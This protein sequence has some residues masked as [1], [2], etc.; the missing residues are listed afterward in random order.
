MAKI[1]LTGATGY[2]GKRLLPLLLRQEH[3]V[4]CVVRDSRRFDVDEFGPEMQQKIRIFESD[5]SDDSAIL[6]LPLEIDVAFYLIHSMTSPG[7]DFDR[8]EE[9]T[10]N[11]FSRYLKRT[12]ARQV[13]YLGGIAN[14][15]T[16]SK[17]LSSRMKVEKNLMSSG[18]PLT[19]LR[20]AI[21]IGSGSA[22]FEIIRDL[23]EKLPVM[24]TPKWLNSRCQPIAIANVLQYLTGV[25]LDGRTYGKTY[26]IGGPDILTYR[27]MLFHYAEVRKLKRWI[28]TLPVLTPRLSSLWLYFVTSISYPLARNLVDSIKNEV[29]CSENRIRELIPQDLLSYKESV[30]RAF[31]RIRQNL[32]ISSWKDAISNPELNSGFMNFIDVPEHGCLVDETRMPF[33]KDVE[34][35]KRNIWA[36]GGTRGWYYGNFLWQIRGLLDKMVG[37]VGLRRGRRSPTELRAGDSLDFWR[38]ILSDRKNGRLLLYAEMKL[39]GEAWLEFRI[40]EEG[41]KN[42]LV[43]KATFRP[44]GIFGRIY[45]YMLLPFHLLI[46]K[47]MAAKIAGKK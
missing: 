24:I 26:D 43:Q 13:I 29:I 39:P 7:S 21:I 38:V 14:D 9:N 45:W 6:D 17:H 27:Q 31:S 47:G 34:T 40:R 19:V 37:G 32:I 16:L 11:V 2:I 3:E 46:F 10:S 22:S 23:V 20:A 25:I 33:E 30:E 41:D 12:S 18:I 4:Y 15:E 8:L 1:L 5:F 35:V 42:M 44:H 36:I 28:I